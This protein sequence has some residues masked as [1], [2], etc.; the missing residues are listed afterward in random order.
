MFSIHACPAH[1]FAAEGQ[2]IMR[3]NSP[4]PGPNLHSDRRMSSKVATA[5]SAGHLFYISGW[6]TRRT[7]TEGDLKPRAGSGARPA[8][9]STVARTTAVT[10][11]ASLEN[12]KSIGGVFKAN[13]QRIKCALNT[14]WINHMIMSMMKVAF[15]RATRTVTR[16]MSRWGMSTESCFLS[17]RDGSI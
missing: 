10:G 5:G 13:V 3:L 15:T 2:K 1:W 6:S 14:R 12:N 16:L 9:T 8:A 4:L 7:G 17:K 11:Q